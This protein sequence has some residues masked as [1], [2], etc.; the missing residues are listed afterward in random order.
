M[1]KKKKVKTAKVPVM[2]QKQQYDNM[3]GRYGWAV[4]SVDVEMYLT[5]SEM[6]DYFGEQC[7][8]YEPL[9]LNCSNWLSWHKTG[10]ATI[11][12]ERNELLKVLKG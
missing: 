7:D 8:E 1:S 10:K 6:V 12:F 2:N 9:C 5:F 4:N 3:V 11:S